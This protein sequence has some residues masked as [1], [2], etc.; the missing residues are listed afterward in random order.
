MRTR[1]RAPRFR[2]LALLTAC[3]VFSAPVAA[4]DAST[5]V[6]E[7]AKAADAYDRGT[8]SYLSEDYVIAARW[9]ERAYR[10]VPTASALL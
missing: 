7:R 3:L 5:S 1:T 8:A 6:D 10:T 9:F 4:N 2:A